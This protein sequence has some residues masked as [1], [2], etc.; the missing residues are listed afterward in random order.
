[1]NAEADGQ[2][3]DLILMD[4]QMPVLDGYSAVRRLRGLGYAH[5]IVA[6]TANAMGGDQQKCLA[7]GCDDYATKPINRTQ[8]FELIVRHTRASREPPV[9][10]TSGAD[11]RTALEP[12]P[13]IERKTPPPGSEVDSPF[14]RKLALERV[15]GDVAMLHELASLFLELSPQ[16]LGDIY[17]AIE[18]G[19]ADTLRRHAHTLK[20]SADNVGARR[21]TQAAFEL[22]KLAT[23]RHP[24]GWRIGFAR[25]ESEMARLLPA[26]E[27]L[28]QHNLLR[29]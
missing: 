11:I 2:P 28:L 8:L 26:L 22:E 10:R 14:D 19:D 12:A 9:V 7:A 13:L 3:F 27:R 6:L 17:G 24:D 15:G 4:M 29:N 25:I 1:L 21:A 5:P 18:L 20:N 23:D 16:M